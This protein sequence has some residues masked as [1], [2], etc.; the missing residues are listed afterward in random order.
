MSN[1]VGSFAIK[2]FFAKPIPNPKNPGCFI[3]EDW[4]EYGPSANLDRSTTIERV[5]RL[6]C[7]QPHDNL[8]NSAIAYAHLRWQFL[9]PHYEAWKS[10]REAPVNGTPISAWNGLTPE[11]AEIFRMRNI[12]TVEEIA[13]ITDAVRQRVGIPHINDI[14]ADAK[15]FVASADARAF[16]ATL[17]DNER[18]IAAQQAQLEDRDEQVRELMSRLDQLTNMFT[19]AQQQ[20]QQAAAGDD[21]PPATKRGPGRPPKAQ[22]EAAA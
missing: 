8:Q 17:A 15:R 4:V 2:R 20:Q 13:D 6:K 7:V 16:S 19:A 22:Q 10:G 3:E 5:S 11:Q 18:R 9:E 12:K 14:I 1:V 21:E